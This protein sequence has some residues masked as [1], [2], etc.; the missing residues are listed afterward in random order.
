[1]ST[2]ALSLSRQKTSKALKKKDAQNF[3]QNSGRV[4]TF[5]GRSGNRYGSIGGGWGGGYLTLG[6][7][8]KILTI[9][10]HVQKI[11]HQDTAK[12]QTSKAGQLTSPDGGTKDIPSQLSPLD[13]SGRGG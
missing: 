4:F 3:R 12:N 11:W 7:E 2:G 5:T 8:Y 6:L 1:M 10:S 13:L 9:L